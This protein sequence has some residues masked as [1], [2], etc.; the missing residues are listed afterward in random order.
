M[1][2]S[3]HA[4]GA[5]AP[6]FWLS[7]RTS[8]ELG[9]Q[10]CE[11]ARYL[12][13]HAGPQG[14]GIVHISDSMPQVTGKLTHQPL[15]TLVRWAQDHPGVNPE[16][17]LEEIL[18]PAL[19]DAISQY[20]RIVDTRGLAMVMDADRLQYLVKEQSA[21]IEGLIWTWALEVF[22]WFVD[23]FKILSAEEENVYV[24]GCTCGLG[25]GVGDWQVHKT[26]GC[27]GVGLMSRLDVVTEERSAPGV[28]AYHEFKTTGSSSDNSADNWETQ[29]QFGLGLLELQRRYGP[30]A[31]QMWVHLL[32]KGKHESEYDYAT[33]SKSGPKFQ[34]SLFCYGWRRPPNLPIAEEE[35]A[36]AYKYQGPDGK[37]HTLGKSY[38]RHPVWQGG[39]PTVDGQSRA[40]WWVREFLTKEQRQA[41]VQVLGPLNRQRELIEGL[42]IEFLAEEK[43]WRSITADLALHPEWRSSAFQ[44]R[45]SQLVRRSWDCRKFGTSYEC[46]YALICHRKEG[47]TDPLATGKFVERT[48][49]HTPEVEQLRACGYT[50]PV[51]EFAEEE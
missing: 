8:Y 36:A 50:V 37:N 46:P 33:G 49:H 16:P 12:R 5:H 28:V 22:P 48:P 44:T 24:L 27:Q 9:L 26:R 31:D 6:L 14:F 29:V 13:K 51:D 42:A 32:F 30:H 11:R 15:C 7:D 38:Q 3:T 41:Q 43:D 45:L 19:T 25:D 17:H 18:R 23:R 34:N 1:S 39:F 40:E 47:W 4:A 21:L 20:Q 2:D 10:L 35:W